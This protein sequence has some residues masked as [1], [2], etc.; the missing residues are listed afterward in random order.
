VE[1]VKNSA[2]LFSAFSHDLIANMQDE[3]L[4]YHYHEWAVAV[5]TYQQSPSFQ[6]MVKILSKDQINGQDF[7]TSF[8]GN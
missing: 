4:T 6:A 7:I 2:K 1:D 3:E 5:Q 8:E